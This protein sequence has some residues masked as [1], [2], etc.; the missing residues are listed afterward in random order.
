MASTRKSLSTLLVLLPLLGCRSAGSGVDMDQTGRVLLVDLAE[1]KPFLGVWKLESQR[2]DG[3]GAAQ[4]A[5]AVSGTMRV[6]PTLAGQFIEVTQLVRSSEGAT[7]ISR[8]LWTRDPGS[9]DYRYWVFSDGGGYLTG[10][11]S[12]EKEDMTGSFQGT[13]DDGSAFRGEFKIALDGPNR[14]TIESRVEGDSG[15]VRATTVY[16]REIIE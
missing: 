1:L 6:Y 2:I 7:S 4:V 13:Q 15:E 14:L 16:G 10:T 3:S 9:R 8:E 12:G 5:A 11:A